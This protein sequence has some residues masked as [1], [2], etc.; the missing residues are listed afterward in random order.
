MYRLFVLAVG[1]F[2][3]AGILLAGPVPQEAPPPAAPPAEAWKP[4]QEFGFLLGSWSG[5]SESGKRLGG[6]VV[7]VTKEMDG[8]YVSYRGMRIF[9]AQEGRPE[10]TMEEVGYFFYDRDR[11]HYVAHF[12]FSTGVVGIY[13]VEVG[14]SSLKLASRELVNYDAGSRSRIIVAGTGS[15]ILYTIELAPQGKDFLPFVESKLSKK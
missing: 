3:G 15:E 5:T 2:L 10:E 7:Q 12:Y 14:A 9:P 13:D 6:S 8:N 4:F 1:W 11:R